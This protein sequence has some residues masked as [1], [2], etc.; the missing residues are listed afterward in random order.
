MVEMRP[1]L[2]FFDV[3][4]VLRDPFFDF[5]ESSQFGLRTQRFRPLKIMGRKTVQDCGNA[6]NIYGIRINRLM[7]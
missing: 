3:M 1:R 7:V 5:S 6:S 2:P 4:V